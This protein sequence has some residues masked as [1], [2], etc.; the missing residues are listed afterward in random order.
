MSSDAINT[1]TGL[2]VPSVPGAVGSLAITTSSAF[3]QITMPGATGG[4]GNSVLL[5][6]N[7]NSEVCLVELLQV[8]ASTNCQNPSCKLT[9]AEEIGEEISVLRIQK[10]RTALFFFF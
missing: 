6:S 10:K 2:S 8:S 3:G 5:V 9:L 1:I 4:P 7:L